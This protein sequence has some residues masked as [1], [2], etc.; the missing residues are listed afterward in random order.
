MRCVNSNHHMTKA[1]RFACVVGDAPRS[2]GGRGEGMPEPTG[3]IEDTILEHAGAL[4]APGWRST[5]HW[6][7]IVG[8]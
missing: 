4:T 8:V 7:A 6:Y 3:S 1:A 5:P 2:E